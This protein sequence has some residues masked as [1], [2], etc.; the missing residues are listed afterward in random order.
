MSHVRSQRVILDDNGSYL[1]MS[2]GCFIVRD[3]K[4]KEEKYPL[5]ENQIKEV[6]LQSGNSISTGALASLGFWDVDVM[7][8]TARGKP[9][10]VMK[11]L[12]DD[13]HVKTRLCQYEAYNSQMGLEIAKQLVL[14]KLSGQNVLLEKYGFKPH[15]MDQIKHHVNSIKSK[16]LDYLR[17]RL[18][19]I[20]GIATRK[21]FGQLFKLI[22]EKIRPF[23]RKGWKAYDGVNNLLNLGYEVLQWKVHRACLKAKLEPFLGF[24]HSVQ[25]TKPSLVIDL[26][27]LYRYLVDDFMFDYVQGLKPSDFTTKTVEA[28]KNRKGKREYLNDAKTKYMMRELNDYF[29][30]KIKLPLIRFGKRQRI[31]TLINEEALLLAKYIRKES[32]DWIP[33]TAY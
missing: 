25:Y 22:P 3:R 17:P 11:S 13:S 16:K 28:S 32:E 18:M 7:V 2:K 5:F 23:R 20:E 9:V 10:A 4:G 33:R 19:Q 26:E 29:D 30:T 27:E 31:E 15:D 6:V 1:G 14:G 12:D 8:M 21:Y 24:L